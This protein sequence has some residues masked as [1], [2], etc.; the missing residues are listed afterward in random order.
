LLA[1]GA[2]FSPFL[3]FAGGPHGST[4]SVSQTFLLSPSAGR[5]FGPLVAG[6]DLRRRL[7][8]ALCGSVANLIAWYAFY[9]YPVFSLYLGNVFFPAGDA[10][11]LDVAGIFAAGFV[12]R[13]IG[14]WL[15]GSYADRRGRSK[16]LVLSVMLMSLGCLIIAVCP[17]YAQIGELA[18]TAL[19][20]AALLQGASL[21]GSYGSTAAFLS[22][23]AT[24]DRRGF[25]SSFTFVTI[26]LGQLLATMTLLML[27]Q[28]L[29]TTA[30]LQA[31]GWRIPFLIGAALA[32]FGFALQRGM[33]DADHSASVSRAGHRTHAAGRSDRSPM[34]WLLTYKREAALAVG[35]TVGGTLAF[36]TFTVYMQQTLVVTAGLRPVQATL[37]SCAALFIFML[38]QPLF[39]LVSDTVGRRPVL[40]WFGVL[41]VLF[42]V[43]IMSAMQ[44]AQNGW[45]AFLLLVA[46]L[47]IVSGYTSI[48]V[49]VKSELFP[50]QVRALG[51]G[52]P[53]ALT[54]TVFGGTADYVALWFK[55]IGHQSWFPWYVTFWILVSLPV[56]L[57]MRE[58]RFGSRF[59]K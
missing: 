48:N 53:Y 27:E 31:W 26:I 47:A 56:Y 18:P 55:G 34:Q 51:T 20:A 57:S 19:L 5:R 52:L 15:L 36:Y 59:D 54:V 11:L 41:G 10:R 4:T 38:L 13:P 49:I 14:S 58:T 37:V 2:G 16:A 22:E 25:Y 17:S 9:L 42:T 43:P 32:A 6:T 29:L 12:M 21:G 40:L 7:T 28:L 30:Q 23:T 3:N 50:A 8:A 33:G 44:H 39:A 46:A 1:V 35:L 45:T 24:A